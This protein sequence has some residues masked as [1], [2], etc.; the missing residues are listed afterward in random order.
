MPTPCKTRPH[1]LDSNHF[2]ISVYRSIAMDLQAVS[3]NFQTTCT[4]LLR[5]RLKNEPHTVLAQ[6]ITGLTE[7]E[8]R[9]LTLLRRYLRLLDAYEQWASGTVSDARA[10]QRTWQSWLEANPGAI[11][12]EF[13]FILL[14]RR[15]RFIFRLGDLTCTEIGARIPAPPP[16][17]GVALPWFA[18]FAT[19]PLL[20]PHQRRF[21][22]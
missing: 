11:E 18:S 1:T 17:A 21:F 4:A 20:W 15:L 14:S 7:D 8:Q 3:D 12:Q 2:S 5:T 19:L 13:W 9:F 10:L 6:H 22:Y 16:T